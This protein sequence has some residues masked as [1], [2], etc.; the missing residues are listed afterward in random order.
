[1]NKH[2]KEKKKFSLLEERIIN[3]EKEKCCIYIGIKL[4]RINPQ[5]QYIETDTEI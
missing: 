3:T 4:M 5:L 1:M 2:I